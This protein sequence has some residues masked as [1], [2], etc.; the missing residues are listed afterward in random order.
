MLLSQNLI[1]KNNVN[2]YN[3]SVVQINKMQQNEE[4][5]ISNTLNN[6]EKRLSELENKVN[7]IKSIIASANRNLY[8]CE[9]L[10]DKWS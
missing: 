1:T 7:I 2:S 10:L 4:A 3:T 9:Q 6:N 5:Y 8:I